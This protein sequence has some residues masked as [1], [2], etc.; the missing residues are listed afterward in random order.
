MASSNVVETAPEV[1]EFPLPAHEGTGWID[2]LP[3]AG[4]WGCP[5]EAGVLVEY[6]AG[7]RAKL[8]T[9][10]DAQLVDQAVP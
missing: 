8:R 1:C 5:A 2:H 7:E 3:S 10:L 9:R 6:A 4:R